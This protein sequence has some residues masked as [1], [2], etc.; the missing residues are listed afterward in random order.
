[1][2][3][4]LECGRPSAGSSRHLLDDLRTVHLGR[5]AAPGV[6]R[7][8]GTLRLGLADHRIS[9]EHA[10]LTFDSNSWFIEDLGS[11]NKTR[12][13]GTVQERALLSDGDWVEVGHTHF[14]FRFGPEPD[15]EQQA[16]LTLGAEPRSGRRPDDLA[17]LCPALAKQ[18]SALQAVAPLPPPVLILGESGTGK[19]RVARAT[20]ARSGRTGPFVAV[21]CGALPPTLVEGELFGYRR[22]AFTGALEDRLGLVRSADRGTLFLDE[23]GDLPSPAQAA[24]LRVLQE[25]EVTPLGGRAV[26]TDVRVVAAT[27]RRLDQLVSSGSFR[28]D[29][30]ARLAG[31]RLTL[32]PLSGRLPDLG[33]VVAALLEKHAGER[34]G[35]ISFSLEAGRA[36][37]RYPWPL[38]IRELDQV[39]GVA[40]ALA[41]DGR[42]QLSHLGLLQELPR[43]EVGL[44]EWSADEQALRDEL[45]NRLRRSGGNITAVAAAMGK[46]RT[47]VQRWLKRFRIVARDFS[48]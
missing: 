43:R 15:D 36:L 31:F 21:N 17:T 11:K 14:L 12:V 29:L 46:G 34:A 42:I 44:P 35:A 28:Q 30:Y 38:N 7:S 9:T 32:P 24:L 20:H 19:E 47:Q 27:H 16:D 37:V 6:Q 18:F 4:V 39:L 25:N 22:G 13:N 40:C 33:A 3:R 10:Q 1:L 8:Q 5:A 48:R 26:R 45:M 2:Y 23:I 41:K